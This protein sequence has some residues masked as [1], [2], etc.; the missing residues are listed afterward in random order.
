[1]RATLGRLGDALLGSARTRLELAAIEYA[2]ERRRIGLQLA[3]VAAGIGCLLIALLLVAA[4][5][6]VS[7]RPLS[8]RGAAARRASGL[9]LR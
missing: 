8:D 6:R 4:V 1:L 9:L 2:E 3:L 7:R 5:E